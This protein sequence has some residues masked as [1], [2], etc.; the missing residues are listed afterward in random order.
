MLVRRLPAIGRTLTQLLLFRR[1]P[2]LGDPLPRGELEPL[3]EPEAGPDR[4]GAEHRLRGQAEV[5]GVEMSGQARQPRRPGG[6]HPRMVDHGHLVAGQ[7]A[8][9]R[10]L[11]DQVVIFALQPGHHRAQ[12]GRSTGR[13]VLDLRLQP[14]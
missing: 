7:L 9:D 2:R 14:G 1:Q 10:G 12:H 11:T 5:E 8:G 13:D 4:A 3:M 6:Q